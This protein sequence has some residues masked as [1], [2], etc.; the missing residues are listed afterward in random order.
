MSARLWL[1]N[2]I[3][4]R[5]ASILSRVDSYESRG[6]SKLVFKLS[7]LHI[8]SRAF[9]LSG[10]EFPDPSPFDSTT[11]LRN[12]RVRNPQK[13]HGIQI[14]CLAQIHPHPLNVGKPSKAEKKKAKM[15]PGDVSKPLSNLSADPKLI[16]RAA[17]EE[18]PTDPAGKLSYSR[19]S[20][21]DNI[22]DSK[23]HAAAIGGI[24]GLAFLMVEDNQYNIH[25]SY[26]TSAVEI[27]LHSSTSINRK[28]R[29]LRRIQRRKTKPPHSKKTGT[30]KREKIVIDQLRSELT[31]YCMLSHALLVIMEP[32][33]LPNTQQMT[34]SSS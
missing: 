10:V 22:P 26:E 29:R 34:S 28:L 8:S 21:I 13:Y 17:A 1:W 16:F 33:L 11:H 6:R 5:W 27:L 4:G 12:H 19:A 18:I 23:S 2:C 30:T 7:T 14:P 3:F 31:A 24:P 25:P 9:F 32:W 15:I 20:I